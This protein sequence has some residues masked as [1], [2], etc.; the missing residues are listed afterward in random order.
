MSFREWKFIKLG[1]IGTIITGKTPSTKNEDNF[2]NKYPFITPRDMDGQKRIVDFTERYLSQQGLE[3]V[4]KQ[5]LD[6][7]SICV[8]CIGSDMGK[9]IL[10]RTKCVTNQQINSITSIKEDYDPFF[11][12]YSLK[13]LKE[14]FHKIAGGSTMPIINKSKFSQIEILVPPLKE[15]KAIAH[16]LSTLDE[17]IELNNKINKTLEDIAQAIFKHW[18][19]DFEFPNEDGEPYKSSGGEMVESE[20][21]MIPKGWEIGTVSDMG[22]VV[23]GA[24]PSKK[25]EDYFTQNG[26]PWIT[27]KD[28]ANTNDL[29]IER[30]SI[31][32]TE[33]G[34]KNSSVRKMPKGTVLFSSRAPIGYI[35][36]SKNE[37]T[38]NQGF[39]SIVPAKKTGFS[40]MYVFCW[41]KENTDIIRNRANG[42]TFKEISGSEMKKISSIIPPK[43]ILVMF[44]NIQHDLFK[45]IETTESENR[46]LKNIRDTL[47]PKLM[48]GEIRVPL[49]QEG[50]CE[51][52]S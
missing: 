3:S 8:S 36:I 39:K 9:V 47:L 27:P 50:D 41:L 46:I 30:G 24:T 17:K 2:G 38:T 25:K 44:N 13:P 31:D 7:I 33:K 19:V 32:I 37:I 5:V 14:Y 35:A 16:I 40:S 10:A 51:E 45:K 52:V 6:G 1:E 20:L 12:Y 42:S 26:I 28:L 22:E 43:N 29:F 23:G 34:L 11:I 21:G 4:S 49:D 48:S 18:F 15:Q